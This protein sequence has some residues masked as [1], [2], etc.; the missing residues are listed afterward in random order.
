MNGGQVFV[1]VSRWYIACSIGTSDVDDGTNSIPLV[2]AAN[3]HHTSGNMTAVH[4][5]HAIIV[6]KHATCPSSSHPGP[7]LGPS[8]RLI[9]HRPFLTAMLK[10]G[11][12]VVRL[13]LLWGQGRMGNAAIALAV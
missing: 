7:P 4:M 2:H 11:Q 5:L 3:M 10:L 1:F 6:T 13:Y 12:S 8:G 9:R